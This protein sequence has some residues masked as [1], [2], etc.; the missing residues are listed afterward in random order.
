[1]NLKLCSSSTDRLSIEASQDLDRSTTAAQAFRS[2]EHRTPGA[3]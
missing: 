3:V 1:M 2:S